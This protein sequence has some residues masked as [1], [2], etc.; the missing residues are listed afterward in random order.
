MREHN[1]LNTQTLNYSGRPT[2]RSIELALAKSKIHPGRS[3]DSKT[4]SREHA[5]RQA[6]NSAENSL[7]R[8]AP[9]EAD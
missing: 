7:L 1:A 4:S 9:E 5:L 6:E 8:F 2:L 3:R